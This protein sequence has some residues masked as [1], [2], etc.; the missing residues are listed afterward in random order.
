MAGRYP[1]PTAVKAL[2][3][4]LR[5]DR[6]NKSEPVVP[7]VPEL[8]E[9]PE[10]V[11]KAGKEIWYR[12]APM[13]SK[14]GVLTEADVETFARYCTMSGTWQELNNWM[15][16]NKGQTVYAVYTDKKSWDAEKQIF[17]NKREFSHMSVMPQY[18]Q[19]K[20]LGEALLRF[21]IQFGM[22]PSSRG[23]VTAKKPNAI[24]PDDDDFYE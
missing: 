15:L 12:Y 19:W 14:L 9:P 1:K 4:T 18:K 3:G 21:E 11:C 20:E 24:V 10:W 22:T 23:K 8:R 5:N 7:L 16:Q 17:V 2:E 13:F 6:T